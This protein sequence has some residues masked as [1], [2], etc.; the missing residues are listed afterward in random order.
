MSVPTVMIRDCKV[1]SMGNAL[2]PEMEVR[3][4]RIRPSYIVEAPEHRILVFPDG[5]Q[6]VV[7]KLEAH[8]S[9]ARMAVNPPAVVDWWSKL[10]TVV[11]QMYGNDAKGDCVIAGKMK[12]IGI[13][14]GSDS[15]T[16]TPVIGTTQ[17]ALSQYA[18]ICGPGDN[19]CMITAVMDEMKAGRFTTGGVVH[20]LDNYVAVDWTNKQLIQVALSIFG[21]LTL[22]INLPND[23]TCTN[24]TW[25][26][27]TSRIVGGHDVPAVGCTP[28]GV[29]ILTWAGIVTITWAAFTSKTWLEE[30]YVELSPDWY[31]NDKLAPNGIDSVTLAQDLVL[32]DGGTVP[33]L[34]GP[35]PPNPVPPD[36]VPPIP[37][38]PVPPTPRP[39]PYFTITFANAIQP[40]Q[41]VAIRPFRTKTLIPKGKCGVWPMSALGDTEG[42]AVPGGQTEGIII[43]EMP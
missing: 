9:E 17:E 11:K 20:K 32:L 33:P 10:P 22:G 16:N 38:T 40:G 12:Q 29:Q 14:T 15:P 31:G 2:A 28:T 3:L 6:R 4:G 37:P 13:W 35:V 39:D 27:T 24:C 42:V 34:P 1:H 5:Q 30:C 19:G 7:A 23:W 25:D 8:W 21:S 18:K 41:V 36:P 26:T 43:E